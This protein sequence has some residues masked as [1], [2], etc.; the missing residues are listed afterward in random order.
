VKTSENIF[1]ESKF[2]DTTDWTVINW[3]KVTKYVDKLQKR[4][5][6]A[7]SENNSRKVKNLQRMLIYSN[8]ALLLAIMKVTQ[9]NKGKRTPG[10]DGFRALSDKKRGELFDTMK[11]MKIRLHTPKP[12]YRKY[13]RK[14]NGKLRSLGIPVIIDRIYQ[15]IIRMALEPQAEVNF[16][17]ISY[18]FR[19]KR[20]C[21]DAI[22]R[23][24]KNIMPGN[25]NWVFEGDFKS[26][27]DTL[28]HDFILK[29]IKGFSLYRLIEKFLKA[30]YVD[31]DVF[32][33]TN[34]GTPQ[35]GLISPLLANMALNGMEEILKITYNKKTDKN[36][37]VSYVTKGKYRMVRYADDF[38][39]FAKSKE[40]IEEIYDIIDPYLK[41]RGLQ[42]ARDKTSITHISKGF[43]FVGFNF[44][45]YQSKEYFVYL[46]K[47]SD[48]SVREFKSKVAEI[49]KQLHGQNVD[50]LIKRLNPLIRGT[51][52]YWKPSATKKTF[53]NMN[54]YIWNKIFKFVKRLHPNKPMKWIKK[55]YFPPYN[56]GKHFDNWIL[57]GP[58]EGNRLIN[59]AWTPIRRHT[60]IQYNHSPYDNSKREYF[61]KREFFFSLKDK[62][63][64]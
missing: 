48:S 39:I 47:P 30:G 34:E 45:R 56:D 61:S 15:E 26:C 8:A 21:H 53:S 58:K 27:F 35:G 36:G 20:G 32:Y 55:R 6:R 50:V 62:K 40:D 38:V 41:E 57:T 43:D 59:M 37:Y 29:Q 60:M 52:N 9:K 3:Y 22:T 12:A 7:E 33:S 13:I 49:C 23:I 42:L 11:T 51:A 16:E 54:Y 5:Y 28:S 64:A 46:N 17:P 44:R 18:G 19:P 25:W 63:Y 24:M 2:P 1:L 31:N 14:K 10:I 4:I